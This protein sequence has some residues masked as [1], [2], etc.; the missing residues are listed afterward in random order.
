M[1]KIAFHDNQLCERGS[2]IAL[3]DY[4]YYNKYYL[5][6][7][8]IIMYD[9]NDDRNVPSVIEKFAKE[10]KLYP[11]NEWKQDADNILQSEKCDILYM[12]KGGEYDGKTA[13]P[14]ICKTVVHCVFNT[15]QPHG[16]IY[17]SI[18]PWV[19]HND[20][21]FSHV[22]HI[23]NLPDHN[24]N[25]RKELNIPEDALVFGRH[26]GYLQFDIEYVK[27]M[28]FYTAK[29]NSNIYFIFVNTQPFCY[30]L[31]NIKHL[32]KI[33]DL[34]E[35][36][37]FIN[38]CDGMMWGRSDGEVFSLS[39][40]EFSFKNKPVICTNVGYGGQVHL[41]KDKAMW[42]QNP[43][44][45]YKILLNFKT[46]RDSKENWNAYEDCS[47]E[48]VMDIFKNVFIDPFKFPSHHLAEPSPRESES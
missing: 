44:E 15:I 18:A 46:I 6:N 17:A 40:G 4:A 41:L 30:S 33:I 37:K 48:K 16:H 12:I 14:K 29:N 34:H 1:V 38:T 24:E 10:F 2:T 47:P 23:I 21:K 20:G 27:K 11:Y 19:Q 32:N 35:K 5:K 43:S 39:Q 8:S 7:E 25:M 22:P 28:V 26:G 3:Y 31:P 45:L 42:Y 13:L 9:N 36:V